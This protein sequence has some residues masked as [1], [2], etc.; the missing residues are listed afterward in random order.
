MSETYKITYSCSHRIWNQRS[1]ID[2][3]LEDLLYGQSFRVTSTQQDVVHLTE[4]SFRPFVKLRNK[5]TG[6]VEFTVQVPCRQFVDGSISSVTTQLWGNVL[7]YPGIR[8]EHIDPTLLSS[9]S[10][11]TFHSDNHRW[12]HHRGPLLGTVLKPTWGLSL[13]QKAE[14]ACRFVEMGGDFVK[15]DE[16]SFPC[17]ERMLEEHQAIQGTL[18]ALSSTNRGVGIYVPHITGII[19]DR[20]AI[21]QLVSQGMSLAMISF[22]I[23]GLDGVSTLVA[24]MEGRLMFWGHRVGYASMAKSLSMEALVQLA[25]TSG[26]DAVH[27]G[28]PYTGRKDSMAKTKRI[29]QMFRSTAKCINRDAWPVFTKTT[30][31]TVPKLISYFGRRVILLACGEIM[32][33]CATSFN[34]ERTKKWIESAKDY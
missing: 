16:T 3:M 1:L 14:M 31:D 29:V 4:L 27:V 19:R 32:S 30:A 26:L 22:L 25:V 28:T 17:A 11:Q 24:T 21:E 5:T 33:D 8:L 12:M 20:D 18:D 23:C 9:L 10:R 2:N 15:E 34:E 6:R 13:A 7:D